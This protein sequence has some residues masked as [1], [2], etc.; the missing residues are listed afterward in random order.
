[1]RVHVHTSLTSTTGKCWDVLEAATNFILESQ[2]TYLLPAGLQT[3]STTRSHH[4]QKWFSHMYVDKKTGRL[5][6]RH[7]DPVDSKTPNELIQIYNYMAALR[8]FNDRTT[9]D[10]KIET[11]W[12]VGQ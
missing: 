12:I 1:M 10:C 7:A 4:L 9:G 2:N 6:Q 5:M 8:D 11:S 3:T